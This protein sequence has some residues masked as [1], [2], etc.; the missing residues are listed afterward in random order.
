M[1]SFLVHS[2]PGVG[3]L[4]VLGAG[5]GGGGSGGPTFVEYLLAAIGQLLAAVSGDG[6][7]ATANELTMTAR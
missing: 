4:N 5:G 1:A 3:T 7:A 2:T 6:A